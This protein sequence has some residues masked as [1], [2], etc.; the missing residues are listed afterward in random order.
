MKLKN[1]THYNSAELRRVF[2]LCM[3][4]VRREWGLDWDKVKGLA[5]TVRYARRKHP[6][7]IGGYAFTG[8]PIMRLHLPR[9]WQA[10]FTDPT[11]NINRVG[12]RSG[13]FVQAIAA[14]FIHEL[15]HNLGVHGHVRKSPEATWSACTIEPRYEDFIESTFS[16]E[17]F[18]IDAAPAPRSK[19]NVQLIRY[20]R[21]ITNLG[22]AETRF[23]RA[24]TLLQKWQRTVKYYERAIPQ[25]ALPREPRRKSR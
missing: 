3:Q 25:A 7:F 10:T 18:P 13:D 2:Q 9:A 19:P 21:A 22:R 5:V 8:R 14:T 1:H 16:I 15:G 12:Y 23:K 24:R 17:R 6:G 11:T 20:Q 4:E